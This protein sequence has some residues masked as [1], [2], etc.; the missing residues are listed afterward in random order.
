MLESY[1]I[2]NCNVRR[3]SRDT[4]RVAF[5]ISNPLD[6]HATLEVWRVRHDGKNFVSTLDG[7]IL[8][9]EKRRQTVVVAIVGIGDLVVVRAKHPFEKAPQFR[10][11]R[12]GAGYAPSLEEPAICLRETLVIASPIDI[13]AIGNAPPIRFPARELQRFFAARNPNWLQEVID[14]QLSAWKE[15]VPEVYIRFAPKT[16]L[17]RELPLLV[18]HAPQLAIA[19]YKELLTPGQLDSCIRA[20]PDA[21]LRHSFDEMPQRLRFKS[22]ARHPSYGLQHLIFRLSDAELRLCAK[23]APSTAFPRRASQS[24]SRHAIIIAASFPEAAS[25]SNTGSASPSLRREVVA[26]LLRYPDEWLLAFNQSLP[27]LFKNLSTWL[28]L[29]LKPAELQQLARRLSPAQRNHLFQY[30]AE[31]I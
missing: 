11:Y 6:L 17:D 8:K 12:I 24:A 1:S 15:R 23:L 29:E 14:E 21:A 25:D 19:F 22:L 30:I 2:I 7:M 3:T 20:H 26:S 27:W 13:I 9:S 18:S 5:E 31:R 10:C 4:S 28:D 16:M